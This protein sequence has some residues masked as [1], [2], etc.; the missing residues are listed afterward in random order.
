[1]HRS[2]AILSIETGAVTAFERFTLANNCAI[3]HIVPNGHDKNWIRLCFA[4]DGFR[5]RHGSWPSRVRI[6]P[7]SLANIRDDLLTAEDFSRITAKIMLVPDGDSM[8]AE[9]DTGKSYH[10]GRDGYPLYPFE[11]PV[12]NAAQWLDVR[13]KSEQ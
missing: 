7:P 1:M 3:W 10:L 13:L 4:I 9:D 6:F 5:V 11:R 12:P 2:P 8:V